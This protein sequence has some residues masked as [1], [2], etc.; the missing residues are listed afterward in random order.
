VRTRRALIGVPFLP[1]ADRE[2]GARRIQDHVEFLVG[3]GWQ[4]TV[5]AKDR[6]PDDARLARALRRRGIPTFIEP[7]ADTAAII[8]AGN[9]DIAILAF[10]HIGELWMPLLRRLSPRTRVVVDS[11]D[12]HFV[13]KARGAFGSTHGAVSALDQEYAS[14]TA[15]EM[16]VYA[17]A[18]AVLAVS[19]DEAALVGSL[20]GDPNLAFVLPDNETIEPS[21]LPLAAR[22]GVV[23]VGNFKHPP[24]VEAVEFL[25]DEIVP[26]LDT[27]L[28]ER[29]PISIVGN[30]ME[31]VRSLA[32]EREHVHRVGW[33]P[34]VL[35]YLA[36]ARVSISPLLHGA[37]TKRKVL[38]SAL[39]ETP[40][41]TTPV[42]TE[43]MPL[44]P[45]KEVFVGRD[46]A[47]LALGTQRLLRDDL[48]WGR[49]ARRARERLLTL[50]DREAVR[51]RFGTLLETVLAREVKP[52][53]LAEENLRLHRKNIHR[54]YERYSELTTRVRE[55][56]EACVPAGA[57][58]AVVSKGDKE[59][60]RFDGR[61]GWHFP[62]TPDGRYFG[63]HPADDASALVALADIRR[64]GASFLMLP[65]PA[66]WW[67]DH[68]PAFAAFLTNSCRLVLRRDDT[69][70]LYSLPPVKEWSV[71]LD[72]TASDAHETV[73]VP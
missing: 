9:F 68:Y 47:S 44:V 61:R 69:G 2:S 35:P 16:N 51:R 56:V 55:A 23:F 45:G 39:L 54:D 22:R 42:G 5:V 37:G 57:T 15:R 7:A 17:A 36:A 41:V 21:P 43:G 26:R 48:L 11:I 53:L 27:R 13:R 4:V 34:S 46:A 6:G 38:Q 63:Y 19:P 1:A 10:W 67:L 72:D 62:S 12:L 28:L 50:Q 31:T 3:A 59:L 73:F 71:T 66:G 14:Q 32:D 70:V 58:V 64:R 30:A 29:H 25:L 20:V 40:V 18:D 24:N 60:I 52:G 33:V 49:F 8:T 65:T